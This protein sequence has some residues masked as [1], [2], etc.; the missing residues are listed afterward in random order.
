MQEAPALSDV[1]GDF[2]QGDINC[3]QLPSQKLVV[4]N[5][6]YDVQDDLDDVER[7]TLRRVASDSEL[8]AVSLSSVSL[9]GSALSTPSNTIDKA[10]RPGSSSGFSG[11]ELW[12]GEIPQPPSV[13]SVSHSSGNCHPCSFFRRNKCTAGKDCAFCHLPH[14]RAKHLG[15]KARERAARRHMR[16]EQMQTKEPEEKDLSLADIQAAAGLNF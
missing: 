6:F 8:S 15:K 2:A 3:R 10:L 7:R 9:G 16:E 4:K 12:W 5:T 14:E 1:F 11:S 13:G